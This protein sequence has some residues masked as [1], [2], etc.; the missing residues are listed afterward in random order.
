MGGKKHN[1][2]V[3]CLKRKSHVNISVMNILVQEAH[4]SF[5]G[6]F[7]SE[8]QMNMMNVNGGGLSNLKME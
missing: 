7:I 2:R 3:V 4:Y 5:S 8:Y 6:T 1:K